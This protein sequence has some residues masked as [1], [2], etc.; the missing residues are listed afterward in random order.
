M[1]RAAAGGTEARK[2]EI[3]SR[4]AGSQGANRHGV[5]ITRGRESDNLELSG[6]SSLCRMPA[7]L[8]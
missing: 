8:L 7:R 3:R 5:T 1:P 4:G 6:L 2:A